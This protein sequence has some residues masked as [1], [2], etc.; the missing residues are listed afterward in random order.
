MPNIAI[1]YREERSVSDVGRGY[2]RRCGS[3][4]LHDC[5]A[6]KLDVV[7]LFGHL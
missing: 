1:V 5:I 3:R 7:G 2:F 4:I 6:K